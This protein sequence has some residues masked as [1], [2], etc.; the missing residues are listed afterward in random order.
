M[1]NTFLNLL[2]K[3]I[4][5]RGSSR[6]HRHQSGWWFWVFEFYLFVFRV[7][8]GT[9]ATIKY[10]HIRPRLMKLHSNPLE[11]NLNAMAIE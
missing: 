2:H 6:G 7:K 10:I 5:Y 9:N 1:Q 4:F 11:C 3:K 8:K